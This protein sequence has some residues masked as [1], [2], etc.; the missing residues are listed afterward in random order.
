MLCNDAIH[1]ATH[2]VKWHCRSWQDGRRTSQ[3]PSYCDTDSRVGAT[4]AHARVKPRVLQRAHGGRDRTR[5]STLNCRT[6][7]AD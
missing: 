4:S 3:N 6:L 1:A 5:I 2:I 7:L